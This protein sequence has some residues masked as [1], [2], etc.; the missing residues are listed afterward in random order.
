M[1][2]K[3]ETPL[4]VSSQGISGTLSTLDDLTAEI[5]PELERS[6]NDWR[7][8]SGRRADRVH[9]EATLAWSLLAICREKEFEDVCTTDFT[10]E[11]GVYQ[12]GH[13]VRLDGIVIHGEY[14]KTYEGEN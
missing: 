9:F 11:L 13:S 6:S 10:T 14:K 4:P 5:K 3:P 1:L 8:T 2:W 7:A 12:R